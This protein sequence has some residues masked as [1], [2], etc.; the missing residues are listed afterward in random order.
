MRRARE[1]AAPLAAMLGLEPEE[2]PYLHELKE[3][4]GYGGMDFG[5]QQR[6]RWARRA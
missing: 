1:T 4:D 3:A 2:L 5:E 6:R